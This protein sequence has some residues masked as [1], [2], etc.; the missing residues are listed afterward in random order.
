M[1]STPLTGNQRSGHDS[2]SL[3][4]SL[5]PVCV[6]VCVC[7]QVFVHACALCSLNVCVG[8]CMCVSLRAREAPPANDT[9]K[10]QTVFVANWS[11]MTAQPARNL[12]IHTVNYSIWLVLVCDV[13]AWHGDEQYVR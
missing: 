2:Q 13:L 5:V 10:S 1:N 4:A 11:H 9:G 3:L 6:C 7:K 8:I 12:F